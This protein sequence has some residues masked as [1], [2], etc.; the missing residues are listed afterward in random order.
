MAQ[1][2]IPQGTFITCTN[3]TYWKPQKIGHNK[4]SK[5]TMH[6]RLSQ[7]LLNID[8]RK[9]S[10]CFV[11]KM[12]IKK[13][14]GLAA[15]CAGIAVAGL[16]GL[17]VVTGGAALLVAAAVVAAATAQVAVGV[18]VYKAAHDCDQT[19]DGGVWDGWHKTVFIEEQPALLNKSYMTCPTGGTLNLML[20]EAKAKEAARMI[21]GHNLKE[22][23][24]QLGSKFLGGLVAGATGGCTL[25]G[26]A[27]TVGFDILDEDSKS[28]QRPD[29]V[30]DVVKEVRNT[31]AEPAIGTGVKAVASAKG[32]QIL[33][34]L[35]TMNN[36][37]LLSTQALEKMFESLVKT[38]GTIKTVKDMAQ[39]MGKELK[40]FTGQGL[41]LSEAGKGYLGAAAGF[42]I[43]QVSNEYEREQERKVEAKIKDLNAED[44]VLSGQGQ[45]GGVYAVG[46]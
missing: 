31:L 11:C 20:D 28:N 34:G 26:V 22:V 2:F 29:M 8:D 5:P 32:Y 10:G 44:E 3:A 45:K 6:T 17:S 30:G 1:A 39:H 15:L 33:G 24:L 27:L 7:P 19:L 42:V 36:G 16:I 25:P 21:A 41:K 12:P 40:P 43:D 9:L 23:G 4:D 18:A 46:V 37:G 14:G 35:I 38:E 13:W